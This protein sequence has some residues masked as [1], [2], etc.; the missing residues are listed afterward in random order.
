SRGTLYGVYT[1]LEEYIGWRWLDHDYEIVKVSDFIQIP[2]DT[3]DRQIP[4]LW[5]RQSFWYNIN[6]YPEYAVKMKCNQLTSWTSD[7]LG[8]AIEYTGGLGHTFATLLPMSEYF[9]EHPEYYCEWNGHSMD[10]WGQ[11]RVQPCLTNPDVFEIVLGNVRKLL[12]QNPDA[13]II[14]VTQNDN[15]DY[16]KCD[17]CAAVD[18]EEGSPAGTML[19]FVNAIAEDI[20]EDYPNVMIDTFAYTYT[21][22]P[23]K[24]TVPREN[25][26]VRLCSI[27]CCFLH[28]I[29]DPDCKKN[30]A[31]M[32]DLEGWSKICDNLAIWD[33]T[34]DFSNF[35]SFHPNLYAIG[36]NV[37]VYVDHGAK[38]I[39]EQG[40]YLGVSGE[41]GPLKAYLLAKL[42]WNPEMTEEEY[43]Y[44]INDFLECYY[45]A[46]W[47]TVREIIDNVQKGAHEMGGHVDSFGENPYYGFEL[48]DIEKMKADWA[49]A[50]ELASDDAQRL[51][52]DRSYLAILMAERAYYFY[53]QMYDRTYPQK[54]RDLLNEIAEIAKALGA[55]HAEVDYAWSI[56]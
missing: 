23:P 39:M 34:T 28:A 46:G 48:E 41:F 27:E 33:Y 8:G 53:N 56:G 43:Q 6:N 12:E 47:T 17:N 40:S 2:L 45:G 24:L 31:F 13:R 22:K 16:C 25:V 42:L 11:P 50:R 19:R 51:H 49:A 7:K 36:K 52:F 30:R 21:R 15:T 14:S 32:E 44:H 1:F 4:A 9:E 38:N 35:C 10:G 20:A 3:N 5:V 29:N 55:P 37:K 18:A 54:A 26:Q